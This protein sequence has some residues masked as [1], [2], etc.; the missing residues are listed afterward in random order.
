MGAA[1]APPSGTGGQ[2]LDVAL[3]IADDGPKGF[4][5]PAFNA[6]VLPIGEWSTAVWEEWLPE[7]SLKRMVTLG[8]QKVTKATN[9]RAVCCGPGAAFV[10]TCSRLRWSVVDALSLVTDT[11]KALNLK[12]DPPAVVI[13]EV[14][15]AVQRWRW[16]NVEQYLTHLKRGGSG[17]GALMEPIWSLLRSSQ[18][19]AEW[20]PTLR[21]SLRSAMCNRQWPQVRVFDAGWAQHDRCVL[22]L[23]SN[24]KDDRR[25]RGLGS[26]E[27]ET[28]DR[29]TLMRRPVVESDNVIKLTPVASGNA[30]IL[31][32]HMR[33]A[34]G[35]IRRISKPVSIAT[36]MG[37]LRGSVV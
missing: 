23:H 36:S 34:S 35:R 30:P 29:D 7:L 26:V 15:L 19:I 18:N 9:A 25:R 20:N 33:G 6:Y 27:S 3:M 10:A 37:T 24:V 17:R 5:D 12:L 1:V 32:W 11:G 31:P 4:C 2:N 13:R 22:C 8:K 21:G 16:R 14:K 28:T